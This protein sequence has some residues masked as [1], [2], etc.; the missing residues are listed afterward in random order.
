MFTKRGERGSLNMMNKKGLSDVVTTV[1]IIL[2]ALAAVIIIWSFVRPAL[3]G[4]GKGIT[5]GTECF[6]TDV[7]VISCSATTNGIVV[8]NNGELV[9]V[10]VVLTAS[11]GSTYVKLLTDLG[12][13]ESATVLEGG[14]TP[15]THTITATTDKV[16]AAAILVDDDGTETVCAPS[17]QPVT[18]TA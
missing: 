12:S 18:C 6:K 7:E 4:A 15:A 3:L 13:L 5:T 2:L 10:K 11:D 14:L 16:S 17:Q 1:L 8:R 9:D